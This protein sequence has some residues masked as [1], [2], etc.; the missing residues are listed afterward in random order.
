MYSKDLLD[1]IHA[2]EAERKY[3]TDQILQWEYK[4]KMGDESFKLLEKLKVSKEFKT[5]VSMRKR[6]FDSKQASIQIKTTFYI[7][8]MAEELDDFEWNESNEEL[9]NKVRRTP[10]YKKALAAAIQFNKKLKAFAKKHNVETSVIDNLV[11]R[12]Y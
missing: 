4:K 10:E 9:G 12:E 8:D 11:A 7:S 3:V 5:L 6:V 2:S 1:F